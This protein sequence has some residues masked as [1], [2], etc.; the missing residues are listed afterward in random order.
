V[1]PLFIVLGIILAVILKAP[2]PAEY[3]SIQLQP[4]YQ[5]F[6]KLLLAYIQTMLF[7]GPLNEEPGWRGFALPKLQRKYSSIIASIII[8]IIWG[9]WHLP[10]YI[11]G[12]Y[13]GGFEGIL[14]RLL[15]TIPL[16]LILTWV[17]M[18]AY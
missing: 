12:L 18:A 10:L 13:T 5:L 16:S 15:W 4:W 9:F 8:G 2:F 1:F 11:T 7:Q 17:F 6:P 14:G 3:Y